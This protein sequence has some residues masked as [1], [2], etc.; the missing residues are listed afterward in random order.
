MRVH[1]L[2]IRKVSFSAATLQCSFVAFSE[3]VVDNGTKLTRVTVAV[4]T[5]SA[6]RS[7]WLVVSAVDVTRIFT[8]NTSLMRCE[9]SA[10][11]E[12][13]RESGSPPRYGSVSGTLRDSGEPS[14]LRR[15]VSMTTKKRRERYEISK[16]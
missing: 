1:C 16:G 12:C 10:R 13:F 6:R 2:F 7:C 11:Q 8:S 5:A 14:G 3:K 4:I 15:P 9:N